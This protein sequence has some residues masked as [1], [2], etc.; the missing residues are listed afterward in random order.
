VTRRHR[1]NAVLAV[2]VS[3]CAYA[4]QPAIAFDPAAARAAADRAAIAWE[5][6]QRPDGAL[7]DYVSRAPTYGY[8]DV[9]VGY[10]MLRAGLRRHDRG[11]T[12]AG[13]RSIAAGLRRPPSRRGVFDVL[14][15]ATAYEFAVAHV[16]R[17]RHFVV[18]RPRW[19]RYLRT[20]RTE[21][22]ILSTGLQACT[23]HPSCFHNHEAVAAFGD[24]Q[25]A[26]TGL[27]SG[28]PGT[29]LAD[30]AALRAR[31][32]HVLT[33][34][35]P[36]AVGRD[37]TATRGVRRA[38][39]GLLS[40]TGTWP[41]AYHSFSAAMVAGAAAN[42]GPR[43]P[44]VT[45]KSLVTA[46]NTIGA[47]MAPDGD[48]AYIGRRHE[49]A[50]ALASAIYAAAV[51]RTLPGPHPRAAGELQAVADR[52]FARLVRVNRFGPGGIGAVPRPLSPRTGLHGVDANELV[53]A[54]LVI[55]LLNLSADEAERAAPVKP[56]PLPADA[57]GAFLEP[58]QGGFA[59]VRHGDLWYA[60]H[61]RITTYDLRYDFGL[62][63]LKRRGADGRW[64][65][66]VRPRPNTRGPS[67]DSAGPVIVRAGVR[68]LPYGQ[69]IA[70]RPG[71]VVLVQG[72]FRS[73]NG[74]WLR[75]GVTFRFAPSAGG[76][77]VSFPLRAGDAAR[78]VTF[79][80][81][82]QARYRGRTVS[83]ARSVASLSI[84]PIGV[85]FG[86]GY[87]SC[88]DEHL[89]AATQYFRPRRDRTVVYTVRARA[90]PAAA[91]ER[92]V[93]A[94]ARRRRDDDHSGPAIAAAALGA[95]G[96][97]GMAIAMGRR[98]RRARIGS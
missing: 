31:A 38:G 34:E 32:L 72:G 39:L 91:G 57:D 35:I 77:S 29:K 76:V 73:E 69:S 95:L 15:N 13:F 41:L 54:A 94:A 2:A 33:V 75:R 80:P 71:G 1:L 93:P 98:R 58:R 25:M 18:L 65:D 90:V 67:Q 64:R 49:Q 42:L 88:C 81:E 20:I 92:G 83:D 82:R 70:V 26:K 50:W 17:D 74:A 10:G 86:R 97:L 53:P 45:R 21:P 23:A 28:V 6:L 47:L 63:A 30:P 96:L 9:M 78:M 36:P 62:V 51:T 79:L 56:A 11:L 7:T 61:R 12:A 46:V 5:R 89:V 59:A 55:F 37:A 48:V 22:Y 84:R 52:A 4:A 3:A 24:L 27:R 87:A 66:V 68:Y 43:L 85:R 44:A 19:E 40:D 14:A 60:V 8:A 16:G